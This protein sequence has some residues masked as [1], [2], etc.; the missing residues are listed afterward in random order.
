[1]IFKLEAPVNQDLEKKYLKYFTK[2][3]INEKLAEEISNNM[4]SFA[5]LVADA[6]ITHRFPG[7]NVPIPTSDEEI[8]E[9]FGNIEFPE[10]VTPLGLFKIKEN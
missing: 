2:I 5:F 3:G 4:A 10:G 8:K 9:V 6:E 7:Y 1:M